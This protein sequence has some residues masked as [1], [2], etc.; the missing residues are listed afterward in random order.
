MALYFINSIFIF[1]RIQL[2]SLPRFITQSL[3]DALQ[4]SPVVFLNGAR[5]TGKSTLVQNNLSEIGTSEQPASYISFD[6]PTQ[7][8]AA[9]AA[10]EAFLKAGKAT[11]VIDEVQLVPELFRSLKVVVDELRLSDKA[12]ANGKY[13]LTG[14]ANILALPQLSD[15]LVGR[16]TVMT[17]YPFCAAEASHGKGD[18]LIR[19]LNMDF[20]GMSDRGL[21]TLDAIK[22]ATFP[23]ISDKDAKER[24]IWFDGYIT[25]ILQR[26]VRMI[27]ELEKISLLPNLLRIL[28]IRAANLINDADISRDVGLNPVTTKSYRNI[29]KMMFLNFDLEP[30]FRNIGKRLVKSPKGFLI[31]TLMI[32][33]ML[34]LNID[35][36]QVKRPELFG[37]LL[38]NFVVTELTK[39]LSFSDIKAKLCHFRTSDGK[40]VDFILEKADGSLFAIEVKKTESV[41]AQD[42]KGIKT[43]AELNEKDFICGVV[44][45]SGNE[46]VPFGENLW[47]VP[48]HVLWQ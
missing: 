16:M 42:F 5:Q 30:W 48:F 22:M 1:A 18:G 35:D 45:Y 36:V 20:T 4:I 47:A 34:D 28:A 19:L 39:L 17:L 27:A 13:L 8:A 25:T 9:A 37:H 40:E 24:R 10:P 33:H 2:S 7:M 3:L 46:V 15:P 11:M 38:E 32:C 29:L 6:R 44:L 43:F 23:K 26:D 31:D 14:S 12:K 21:S 41:N